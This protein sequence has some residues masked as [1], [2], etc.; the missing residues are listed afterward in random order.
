MST[1]E[2]G[3]RATDLFDERSARLRRLLELNA[4]RVIVA[5][6]CELVMRG[7]YGGRLQVLGHLMAELARHCWFWY[8][9]TPV[10][11]G[12]CRLNIY[13]ME[14]GPHGDGYGCPFCGKG[15]DPAR[16]AEIEEACHVDL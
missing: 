15:A 3:R 14:Q 11:R 7:Y 16:L 2:R 1:P 6:E 10:L 5:G 4:P 9:S 8:I 13:H 12:L